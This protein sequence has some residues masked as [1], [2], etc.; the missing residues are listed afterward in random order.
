MTTIVPHNHQS[1]FMRHMLK[2]N[3]S[4]GDCMPSRQPSLYDSSKFFGEL[5][6]AILEIQTL[7]YLGKTTNH[8]VNSVGSL[9]TL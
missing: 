1:H 3:S 2:K 7:H 6:N 4:R 5:T 8:D 9:V